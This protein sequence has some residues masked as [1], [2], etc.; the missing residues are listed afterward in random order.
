[1]QQMD[2]IHAEGHENHDARP[3]ARRRVAAHLRRFWIGYALVALLLGLAVLPPLVNVNRFQRRIATS[4]GGSL[5]RP[6][7]L[8]NISMSVFPLPGFVIQNL[9]VD[10]D[11]AFGSEPIIRANTVRATLRLSSLWRRRVEFSTISFT[12]P[13]VNLVHT[14]A[15]K[16]NIE[17]VLM[18]ASRVEA[19]PTTQRKAGP[20]PRFPYIEATGARLN[21]KLE[22]E[23]LPFSLVD[24]EFALWSPDPDQWRLRL[25]A[26]PTR[27]DTSISNAGTV[28]L[29]ATLGRG[30]SLAHIPL[31]L[32]GQW[33]D[34]PMGEA[35]RMFTGHDAGWRGNFALT[36]NIRGTIGESAVTA[37][38]RLIGARRADFVPQQPLTAEAECFATATSV[39]H[40]FQDLR[41]S[42]P[43]GTSSGTPTVAATGEIPNIRQ[44]KDAQIQIGTSGVPASTLL[45]WLRVLTPG[46]ADGVTAAGTLT[47]SVSYN[48]AADHQWFGHLTVHDADVRSGGDN[49][50]SLIKG[51]ISLSKVNGVVADVHRRPVKNLP[52]LPEGFV[53]SSTTLALGGHDPAVVDGHLDGGGYVLHLAGPATVER[54]KELETALPCL[55]SGLDTVTN[56]V[57][58]T[59]SV[60]V[61]LT[62][63]HSWGDQSP[64]VWQDTSQRQTTAA[65]KTRKPR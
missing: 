56:A 59:A 48:E 35:S 22:Q 20:A 15:G 26:H 1:M 64:R 28:E 36:T 12:E 43:P 4:I 9:V 50:T 46:I 2:P 41:C 31:N 29:E 16:W 13:S 34:A 10:E 5:G 63:A 51:D 6:V 27:T 54:L 3:R 18:Q 25:R 17:E 49:S 42:L 23:K 65:V 44:I 40:G 37:R 58:E 53:L 57:T 39:F 19:A 38:L 62:S 21:F 11:P 45:G 33:R 47:G 30:D 55:G 24:S 7:H 8:D 14:S 52:P 61:D 32:T 60:R